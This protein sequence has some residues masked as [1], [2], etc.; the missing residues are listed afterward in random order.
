M[1]QK[2]PNEL[3]DHI[4]DLLAAREQ[5][6][7]LASAARVNKVTYDLAIPKLYRTITVKEENQEQVIYG[8]TASFAED[9]HGRS[10]HCS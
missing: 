8:C 6:K 5:F 1:E 10:R 3:I 9:S 2:L 4:L 7:S